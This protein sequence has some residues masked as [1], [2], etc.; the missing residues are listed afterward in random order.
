[1]LELL[2]KL[3]IFYSLDAPELDDC[4]FIYAVKQ[5]GKF[6]DEQ[7]NIMCM[8][9]HLRY[10]SNSSID[11]IAKEFKFKVNVN[12]IDLETLAGHKKRSF[13]I[14]FDE[15]T[16]EMTFNVDLYDEHFMIHIDR[17]QFSTDYI[18][19]IDDAPDDAKQKRY[20]LKRGKYVWESF[21]VEREAKRL[22]PSDKLVIELM[23]QNKFIPITFATAGVMKT[24][25]YEN[26]K[27]AKYPLEYDEKACLRLITAL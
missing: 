21:D 25:L 2:K 22:I 10:L 1:M 14:R 5:T 8:R 19:H 26:V 18:K 9:V 27:S 23:N 7:L 15:A 17:T 20:K 13:V 24:T 16:P 6:T 4:C 11:Q 3:Q 12:R